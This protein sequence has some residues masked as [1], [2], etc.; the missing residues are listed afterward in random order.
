MQ[1][2]HGP[3]FPLLRL[4]GEASVSGRLK[5]NQTCTCHLT[6]EPA[7]AAATSPSRTKAGPPR[8]PSGDP[9]KPGRA[10]TVRP[11]AEG[12]REPDRRGAGGSGSSGPHGR[13]AE[14]FSPGG[15]G[16]RGSPPETGRGARWLSGGQRG[17]RRQAPEACRARPPAPESTCKAPPAPH[18][19]MATWTEGEPG[20]RGCGGKSG[21]ERRGRNKKAA[22][23]HAEPGAPGGR[24][25][26][27]ARGERG[28]RGAPGFTFS[29]RSR[30]RRPP[31]R[32]GPRDAFPA[33]GPRG[34]LRPKRCL[35]PPRAGREA[36]A[37][38]EVRGGR[39]RRQSLDARLGSESLPS[40]CWADAGP[41]HWPKR[42]A[43]AILASPQTSRLCAR[44]S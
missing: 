30:R 34:S 40:G 24:A 42:A 13:A 20:P 11:G 6:S 28:P 7:Q 35:R 29:C 5:Q 8:A 32:I 31:W 17:R 1:C 23:R 33:G 25:G 37:R 4:S 39:S 27:G 19:K 44:R 18:D 22:P 15:S 21:Q 36:E 14:R 12:P 43:R 10:R 2:C 3:K 16:L 9:G 38:P 26:G 41:D